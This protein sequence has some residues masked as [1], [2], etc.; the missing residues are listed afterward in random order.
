[1]KRG[2]PRIG[3]EAISETLSVKVPARLRAALRTRAKASGSSMGS[4]V[5]VAID[6]YLARTA[7]EQPEQE[8]AD[9]DAH[10]ETD[11]ED[12]RGPAAGPR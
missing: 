11:P 8:R 1:M 4:I 6:A 10:A 7:C 12:E 2:R 5:R 3:N 9:P